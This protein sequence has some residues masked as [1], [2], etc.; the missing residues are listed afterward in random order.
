MPI[1]PSCHTLVEGGSLEF[2]RCP[3]CNHEWT[4]E[5]LDITVRPDETI[6]DGAH[7][8]SNPR[9]ETDSPQTGEQAPQSSD[10]R[11]KRQPK[12]IA[13]TIMS[14]DLPSPPSPKQ[15][16]TADDRQIAETMDSATSE[17]ADAAETLEKGSG[18]SGTANERQHAET[19]D[20]GVLSRNDMEQIS[21]MWSESFDQ[22][23]LPGTSIKADSEVALAKTKVVIKS[24]DLRSMNEPELA[25]ADYE[26]LQL[27]GEGGMGV[28]YT[29]RQASIDRTVAVKMLKPNAASNRDQ[30]LKFLAEAMVTGELEHPNIV[31]IYDL[32]SNKQ[33]ALFYSMMRV[34]GT[35]W[36]NVIYEKSFHENLDIVMRV[37]DAVAFAHSHN[38]VHRDLKPDNVMLGDFG[39][40][41]LMDWGLA[42]SQDLAPGG[43]MG[44]TPAYMAPEMAAGPVDRVGKHSD[45]YLLGAILYEIISGKRPHTGKDVMS[46]IF[47]AAK[48]E[49][50]PINKTGELVNIALRA[51]AT[52]PENRYPTV[53]DF[54]A[55]IRGYL[56]H[57]ESISLSTRAEEELTHARKSDDYRAFAK[58][59]FGF[60]EAVSLWGDNDKAKNGINT[61]KLAYAGSALQ[62]GDYDLGKSLLDAGHPEQSHLLNQIHAGQRE[63]DARQQ[64]LKTAK[65][66]GA[67][68]MAVL[69]LVITT[70]AAWINHERSIAVV[71]QLEAV[72]QRE[73]AI[74]ARDDAHTQRQQAVDARDD[75]DDQRQQAEIARDA[76]DQARELEK[77]ARQ[78]EEY[79]AYIARIGLASAKIEENAF[80]YAELLLNDCPEYL[81][82]WEWGRLMYLCSQ[83]RHRFESRAP[84]DCLAY[85][86]DG[87]Q[88]VSGGWDGTATIWDIAQGTVANRITTG[89]QYLNAV[90]FSPDGRLIAT[91]TNDKQ[92]YLKIW[93]AE[94]GD[95][96]QSLQG[97]QDAVLSVQFSRDGKQLLSSSYDQTARLW[98]L[99]TGHFRSFVG[100]DWWVW[101]ARFSPDERQM[102]TASQDGTV[103]VW[104]L[105]SGKPGT[106]FRGHQT[107]IFVADFSP[108][109]R[110]VASGGYDKRVLVWEPDKLRPFDFTTL[111]SDRTNPP[112]EFRSLDGHTA[113]VRDLQFSPDGRLVM[114]AGH[115]NTIRLWNAR[116]AKTVKVLRGHAGRVRACRF[117]SDGQWVL[118]GSHDGQAKIWNVAG[119][120]EV[121]I[122]QAQILEGHRDAVLFASFSRDG[123]KIVTASRDRTARTWNFRSGEMIHSLQEGHQFLASGAVFFPNG[124]KVVTGALDNTTRIWETGTG[125]QL[126]RLRDTGAAAAIALSHNAKWLLTGS[127][128]N[129][130]KFWDANTGE[131][132]RTFEGHT[133][134][135]TSVAFSQDDQVVFTG[136]QNGRGRLWDAET[137]KLSVRLVGHSRGITAAR[138]S[139]DGRTLLTSSLD[140]TVAQWDV[141]SG[142][143]H[144]TLSLRHPDSV[145][146]MELSDDGRL[147]L[148]TCVDQKVRIWDVA[149]RTVVGQLLHSG[150]AISSA[151]ISPDQKRVLTVSTG[152]QIRLWELESGQQVD[153]EDRAGLFHL[154]SDGTSVWSAIFSPTGEQILTVG[155]NEARLWDTDNGSEIASF[156]PHSSVASAHFSPDGTRIVTGSWDNTARIWDSLS[157]RALRKLTGQHTQS[158]NSAVYSPDGAHV[159]TASDD[160]TAVLWDA[161]SGE[162]IIVLSGH[163]G[164]VRSASFSSDGTRVVTA[165]E[166]KTARIWDAQTGRQV[167]VLQGHQWSVQE[168]TFSPDGTRVITASE[169]NSAKLWDANTGESLGFSLV[170][171]TASVNSARFS[172][173]G[174]RAITGSQDN[175]VKIWDAL[176]GKEI[177]TLSGHSQ[178]VTSVS[179]SPDGNYVLTSSR[180]G[181]SIVWPAME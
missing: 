117:S 26:L 125:T 32:G 138:F 66:I 69:F 8:P 86:P 109:G 169:D 150:Q 106:P 20:S 52:K 167:H 59:L 93:N 73:N 147:A 170:A 151:V 88:F 152:N 56:A 82:H 136:D 75:A 3:I 10:E 51:M 162:P 160:R 176:T 23:T 89:A 164:S 123:E 148:T 2:G 140:N 94:S 14:D 126:L 179:F 116:T 155:G 130:A 178:A 36:Q 39:E 143:E 18:E 110:Y 16:D 76:A 119:Y 45:I 34:K 159:L 99:E 177:L 15:S 65:R 128:A 114:S 85:S 132:I 77:L 44:G 95:L 101:S 98:D 131:L 92:G 144:K 78:K 6:L 40:V 171:H 166:D 145:L 4:A 111:V 174:Q 11:A 91:G 81:R 120:Q 168:A 80:D 175:S 62:K 67:S 46:C 113:A 31:P 54:Q 28:V 107:P 137:G 112:P 48:N 83:H 134:D 139:L 154:P 29:A 33:G 64:R 158:V 49:I 21:M 118:S 27:L 181:T 127:D 163:Q 156:T 102:V 84:I 142:E 121:R 135:V 180:D 129:T 5:D 24:R 70:A 157:G 153:I 57:S 165:S 68:L 90:G 42:L 172:P 71:A 63:R 30:R 13:E 60:E 146:S 37:A 104:D 133:A 115:D 105:E 97:H 1:C 41:L 50:Q 7:G 22:Q 79:G 61:A 72:E 47:A 122:V 103:I 124:K 149:Q 74:A 58:A 25:G 38:V 9:E 17:V 100:H 53:G 141:E 87:N 35:P 43:G 19:L 12:D 161:N 108:D 96:V 55:A 173:D